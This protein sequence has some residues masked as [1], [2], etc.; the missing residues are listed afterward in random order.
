MLIG[1]VTLKE[2]ALPVRLNYLTSKLLQLEQ[3][4]KFST[5][6]R[7]KMDALKPSH[8]SANHAS[9]DLPFTRFVVTRSCQLVVWRCHIGLRLR[10]DHLSCG[11]GNRIALAS[12]IKGLCLYGRARLQPAH[13]DHH[14]LRQ[15]AP[16]LIP[17]YYD[18]AG[19]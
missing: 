6:I 5:Y 18:A 17:K 19:A 15:D 10:F 3:K 14:C 4:T 7:I 8:L 9:D 13:D 12:R 16:Y 2:L 1:V 11:L